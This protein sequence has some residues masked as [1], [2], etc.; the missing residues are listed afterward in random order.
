MNRSH[1]RQNRVRVQAETVRDL[2]LSASG[3]LSRKIGGPSVYPPLPPGITNLSYANSFKWK[4]STGEDR[5]RRGMYTFFKRTAPHPNLT[6]F[7]CPDANTTNVRRTT[8][9]TP[10]QALITLNNE[11]F[12]ETAR[13]MAKRVLSESGGSDADRVTYGIRLVATRKPDSDEVRSFTELL[14]A[15]RAYYRSKPNDAKKMIA[16][17]AV[18]GI[19]ADEN[20]S[21]VA[22]MRMVM[23]LDEFIVRD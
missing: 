19:A 6:S 23:N 7:D 22:T 14:E 11:V 17:H 2:Y 4:T 12:V 13:R 20:A 1:Y 16:N 15:S 5:Y 18:D 3:L 21:W 8:S 10:L 9:N